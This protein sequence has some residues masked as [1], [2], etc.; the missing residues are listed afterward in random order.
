MPG[1]GWVIGI[2]DQSMRQC[3]EQLRQNIARAVDELLDD[4]W[5]PLCIAEALLNVADD[6]MDTVIDG[7]AVQTPTRR[8][9]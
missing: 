9:H 8:T 1:K 4:G 3:R 2:A 5:E 7:A 6:Y